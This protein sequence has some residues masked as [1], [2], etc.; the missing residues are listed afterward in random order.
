MFKSD[1]QRKKPDS[2]IFEKSGG[3]RLGRRERMGEIGGARR[4]GGLLPRADG[5]PFR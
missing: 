5:A 2:N 1:L 3:G 4:L